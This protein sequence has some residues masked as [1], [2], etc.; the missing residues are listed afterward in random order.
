MAILLPRIIASYCICGHTKCHTWAKIPPPLDVE[1]PA[2]HST[3]R[4]F[5]DLCL[6]F[7][8]SG[9]RLGATKKQARLCLSASSVSGSHTTSPTNLQD[10][11]RIAQSGCHS[12]AGCHHGN[13]WNHMEWLPNCKQLQQ[14]LLKCNLKPLHHGFTFNAQQQQKSSIVVLLEHKIVSYLVENLS[15]GQTS[16]SCQCGAQNVS[17]C[18]S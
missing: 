1:G 13:T 14:L 6:R 16:C 3:T 9:W 15:N 17:V 12:F 11:A 18:S 5:R 10:L 4:R 8:D 2:L 7:V